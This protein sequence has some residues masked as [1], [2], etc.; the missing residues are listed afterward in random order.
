[1][2]EGFG[3]GTRLFLQELSA[4][5]EKAWFDAN[6]T[7]YEEHFLAPAKAFVESVAAPLSKL[8][9]KVEAQPRVNGSI[10]RINRDIRFSNDKTPY[11]DHLDLWFWEGERKQAVSG[12]FLRIADES[13]HIGVGAHGFDKDRLKTFRTRVADDSSR[14]SLAKAVKAVEKAGWQAYGETYK[15][16]PRD[17]PTE[18]P[19]TERFLKHSAL[20]V[21]GELDQPDELDSAKFV[22][23]CVAQWKPMLP[24]HR[25]LVDEVQSA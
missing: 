15:R 11:K 13:V 20:W 5:N 7:R 4:N 21:G 19:V 1:M 3:D 10:F 25:W 17:F 14:A 8:A 23:W 9:P 6:R 16:T 12:F 18:D 22:N 2:F 24:V